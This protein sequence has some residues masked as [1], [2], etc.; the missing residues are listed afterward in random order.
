LLLRGSAG[1]FG[2]FCGM[3]VCVRDKRARRTVP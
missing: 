2:R 3:L 1:I